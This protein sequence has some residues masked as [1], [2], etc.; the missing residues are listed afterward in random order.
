MFNFNKEPKMR[1]N[2]TSPEVLENARLLL[3]F[4][5]IQSSVLPKKKNFKLDKTILVRLNNW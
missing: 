1:W 5:A 2:C 4:H 3:P